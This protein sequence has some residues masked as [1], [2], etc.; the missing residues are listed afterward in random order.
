M[1]EE[2]LWLGFYLKERNLNKVI[3]YFE[4]RISIKEL[5]KEKKYSLKELENLAE[6]EFK[7]AEK[8]EVKI[9]FRES[10]DY[11]E[12][13]KPL[14]YAPVFLYV[15]G[16][17]NLEKPV[18]AIIGSRKPTNYGKEVAYKFSKSLAE[19]GIGIISGLARGIDS[20]A[21]RACLEAD[22]YTIAVLGS[23]IDVIYPAENKDL[24]EKIIKNNGAIISEFPFGTKPR[25]E[26]FPM[27]NRII[28]GLSHGVLV[29]EAGKRSGTLIT[30]KW[31][32]NQGKEVLAVPGNVFSSQSEGTH[33]LLKQGAVLVSSPE[34]II[35][36][37]D[38]EI[39]QTEKDSEKEIIEVSQEEKEILGL[40]SS[41]PQ[42]IEE[43]FAKL[44]KPAFEILSILTDLELKG[45][46]ETLPGKYVKLKN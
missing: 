8:F 44:N 30:A 43:I 34:D 16:T 18:I 13:L 35:E 46:I 19:K 1:S 33:Y 45:L 38:L 10:E 27:R 4:E 41:Y 3:K 7:K 40:L 26:N 11:P 37:L 2:F 39:D 36:Y 28:S 24:Y 29:V 15:K 25:K 9:F 23:G 31:A 12:I 17:F 5:I 14:P 20:I 21:H 42:H 32:L 22:G 6:Q